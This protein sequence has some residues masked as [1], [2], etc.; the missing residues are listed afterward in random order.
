MTLAP[1]STDCERLQEVTETDWSS[2]WKLVRS[3]LL[4]CALRHLMVS[5]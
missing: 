5:S 3:R 1:L 2:F 4:M